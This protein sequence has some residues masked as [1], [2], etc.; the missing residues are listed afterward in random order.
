MEIKVLGP[1]CRNCVLLEQRTKEALEQLGIDAV[2]TKVEDYDEIAA[3][4]VLKTPGLVI[5]ERLI[6][7]GKVPT[8]SA[9]VEIFSSTES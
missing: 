1:G 8:T 2:V 3:Y 7:S 6:F 5:S 4:G 9:L